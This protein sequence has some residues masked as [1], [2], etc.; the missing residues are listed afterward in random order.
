M[1]ADSTARSTPTAHVVERSRLEAKEVADCPCHFSAD[2]ELIISNHVFVF[3]DGADFPVHLEFFHIDSS[4]RNADAKLDCPLDGKQSHYHCFHCKKHFPHADEH[5]MNA[6]TSD[7][8]SEISKGVCLRPF[9]KLKKKRL[10]FHCVVCDQGFSERGKLHLHISKHKHPAGVG[11]YTTSIGVR[12]TRTM[13]LPT[14]FENSSGC[15]KEALLEAKPLNSPELGKRHI[16]EFDDVPLDLSM[17]K[18]NTSSNVQPLSGRVSPPEQ[19][20]FTLRRIAFSL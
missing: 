9:C 11:G 20:P 10:H 6:C 5:P 17:S 7:T 3:H 13:A 18:R 2:D 14:K 4:C 1:C 8:K 16:E 19:L 15:S 12:H